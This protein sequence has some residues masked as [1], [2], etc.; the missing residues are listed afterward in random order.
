MKNVN[1][2]KLCTICIIIYWC[3]LVCLKKME[4]LGKINVIFQDLAEMFFRFTSV[5]R[6]STLLTENSS[7]LG[8]MPWT[9]CVPWKMYCR[10]CVMYFG[11]EVGRGDQSYTSKKCLVL[12]KGVST[13]NH[14]GLTNFNLAKKLSL[15]K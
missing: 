5:T 1:N 14:S 4:L 2:I 8:G 12:P 10:Q 6:L 9:S 13:D 3:L 7:L 15:T 11:Q